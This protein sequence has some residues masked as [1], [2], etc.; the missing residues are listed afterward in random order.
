MNDSITMK[1]G[2]LCIS[3][4][5]SSED[6]LVNGKEE[7]EKLC[8]FGKVIQILEGRVYGLFNAQVEKIYKKNW[9]E[10]FQPMA[11]SFLIFKRIPHSLL[12]FVPRF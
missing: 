1:M 8:M 11:S 9:G 12:R 2:D 6:K 7:I 5:V 4:D 3:N 10:D